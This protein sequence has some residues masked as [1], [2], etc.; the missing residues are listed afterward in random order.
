MTHRHHRV[1][2]VVAALLAGFAVAQTAPT[3]PNGIKIGEGR[4]HPYLTLEGKY[5]ST[6]GLFGA[7]GTTTSSGDIAISI[8]PGLRF[9][10]ETPN[11]L[12]NFDGF[13]EYLWYTGL[14]SPN[15]RDLSR[16]Q[17]GLSLD[18][19]FNKAGAIEFQVGDQLTRSDRTNNPA[20]GIGLV[21]LYNSAYLAVPIHPGGGAIEVAPRVRWN[22]EF[23]SPLLQSVPTGCTPG[24]ILCDPNLAYALNY[25][26]LQGG[27]GAKWKFLPKTAAVLD[28]TFDYRSYFNNQVSTPSASNTA[29]VPSYLLRVQGGLAGLITSHI[30]VLLLVGGG[31]D[32]VT[33]GKT[34]IGQAEVGYLGNP[35]TVRAGY[36]RTMQPVPVLGVYGDDRGY[37]EMTAGFLSQR[38]KLRLFGS[39]DYLSYYSAD[40]RNDLVGSGEAS[41]GYS[42]FSWWSVALGYTIQ[43]RQTLSSSSTTGVITQDYIRHEPRLTLTFSY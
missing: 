27:I 24:N 19:A 23:F 12:V 34:V 5:D 30:Q 1:V 38:L 9:G 15:A 41:I 8:R 33:G 3:T 2:A 31:G 26:N 29:N 42:I 16:F 11:T 21:S 28:A 22:V 36:I 40:N 37:A 6:A 25:S 39:V 18:T 7:P 20:A 13:G 32:W 17:G 10:L 14:I 43:G 4:L 35:I